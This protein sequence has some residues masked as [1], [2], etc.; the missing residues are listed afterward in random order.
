M[1]VCTHYQCE[2]S[3]IGCYGGKCDIKHLQL[4]NQI[5]K[6][7]HW[8]LVFKQLRIQLNMII[9]DVLNI[10][11][12]P[13]NLDLKKIVRTYGGNSAMSVNTGI[14]N[15]VPYKP[16]PI[17]TGNDNSDSNIGD[18]KSNDNYLMPTGINY[19]NNYILPFPDG[20]IVKVQPQPLSDFKS[21]RVS[22]RLK[23]I[24]INQAKYIPNIIKP[25]VNYI[26]PPKKA[27]KSLTNN[28]IKILHKI[29]NFGKQVKY[30]DI[31]NDILTNGDTIMCS[32]NNSITKCVNWNEKNIGITFE[33][34]NDDEWIFKNVCESDMTSNYTLNVNNID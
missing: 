15:N 27:L 33:V 9:C 7:Y 34:T 25:M 30:Q 19:M 26:N 6:D 2:F 3:K 21:D 28:D 14:V 1:K 10:N 18:M 13:K 24:N 5:S 17:G 22:A 12:K 32:D 8:K 23:N 20:R 29:F 4:H 16:S 31:L 11:I